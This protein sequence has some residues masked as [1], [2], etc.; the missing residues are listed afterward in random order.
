LT[1]PRDSDTQVILRAG[2]RIWPKVHSRPTVLGTAVG[3][4]FRQLRVQEI[5]GIHVTTIHAE[6]D[7][8]Q[9]GAANRFTGPRD[10]EERARRALRATSLVTAG[11]R[12]G[13]QT[14]HQYV[15][16]GVTR[17]ARVTDGRHDAV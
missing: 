3:F 1:V 5:H 15:F 9:V 11:I 2:G 14:G 17:G 8:A 13:L 10:D 12:T 6:N 16:H 4:P 7:E